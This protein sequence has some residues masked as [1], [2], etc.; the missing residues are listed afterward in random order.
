MAEV[1]QAVACRVSQLCR[2]KVRALEGRALGKPSGGDPRDSAT[3]TRPLSLYLNL[4]C[5]VWGEGTAR[6]KGCGKSAPAREV[7]PLA[8]QTPP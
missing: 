6:V 4:F 2:R 7:T 1:G 3:E 5:G 8:W